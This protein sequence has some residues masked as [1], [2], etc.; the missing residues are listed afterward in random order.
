METHN[1][2]K[3]KKAQISMEFL[4]ILLATVAILVMFMPIFSK[5]QKSVLFAIDVYNASS[6]L[7]ELKT[8]VA[9]LNSL[10][11]GSSF[12]FELSF[13]NVVDFKCNNKKAEF[14]LK[15]S[16]QTKN[17]SIDL[18]LDCD[19]VSTISK[20][21]RFLVSKSDQNRLNISPM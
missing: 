5:L 19:F 10:D 17:L 15:N 12:V 13:I 11:I 9:I 1:L 16:L 6:S 2:Y 7:R 4:V 21:I 8:N 20:R 14:F 3:N 18:D